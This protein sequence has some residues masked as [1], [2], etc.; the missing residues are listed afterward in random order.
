MICLNDMFLFVL[1]ERDYGGLCKTNLDVRRRY[2]TVNRS[3]GVE[4]STHRNYRGKAN[5]CALQ[6]KIIAAG[7]KPMAGGV[8]NN[9]FTKVKVTI[10]I[11][12]NHRYKFI[13]LNDV[14]IPIVLWFQPALKNLI[15]LRSKVQ[16][17]YS[18]DTNQN[19]ICRKT[20]GAHQQW[21]MPPLSIPGNETLSNHS[22]HFEQRT[23]MTPLH[24][25]SCE[26]LLKTTKLVRTSRTTC[27]V[28]CY[29]ERTREDIDKMGGDADARILLE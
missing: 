21:Q 10:P 12:T 13:C 29:L 19:Q 26:R 25:I 16:D 4:L 22:G 11:F 27:S 3:T 23:S 8:H 20:F 6:F 2:H 15:K 17:L 9:N 14:E 7:C 1:P 24:C 18:T 28:R 5:T